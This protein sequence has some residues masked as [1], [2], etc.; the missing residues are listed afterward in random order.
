MR[1]DVYQEETAQIARR[2]A[3]ILQEARDRLAQGLI[4]SPLEQNGVLHAIQI[5]VE[6]SIGKA[7]HMLKSAGRPIAVSAYDTFALLADNRLIQREQLEQWNQAIGLRNRIVHDY[8]NVDFGL[9]TELI[10]N[11]GE[12]F[13]IDFLLMPL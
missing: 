12:Q 8:M 13:I 7:K 4:L 3:A 9:V 6:N 1:L 2:Q 10:K 5:L 11:H